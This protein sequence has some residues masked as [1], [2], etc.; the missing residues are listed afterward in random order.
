MTGL[1][2]LK[3]TCMILSLKASSFLVVGLA[4]FG[5][6]VL[7]N[8]LAPV[9]SHLFQIL[10]KTPRHFLTMKRSSSLHCKP[11]SLFYYDLWF[12]YSC[13]PVSRMTMLSFSAIYSTFISLH[14]CLLKWM[15]LKWK[16]F[17]GKQWCI[18]A[19]PFPSCQLLLWGLWHPSTVHLGRTS[20]VL[21]GN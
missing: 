20:R 1:E 14:C 9:K 19:I 4:G 5:N 3:G 8:S 13:I 15:M 7:G 18:L 17:V 21:I 16:P 2:I 11:F 6:S 12:G 10:N